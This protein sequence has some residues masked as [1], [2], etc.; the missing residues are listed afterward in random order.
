MIKPAFV[1]M[2]NDFYNSLSAEHQTLIL[3]A[4]AQAR[5]YAS[6][7]MEGAMEKDMQTCIDAG[8]IVCEP[9]L[10]EFEA[11]TQ[12]VRDTLGTKVWGEDGYAQIKEIAGK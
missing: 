7:Y 11:A 3:D 10:A 5:E 9:D 2:S 6:Q 12:S 1:I 8:M 4:C